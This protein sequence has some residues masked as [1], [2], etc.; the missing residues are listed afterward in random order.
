[1]KSALFVEARPSRTGA[2]VDI[3]IPVLNEERALPGAIRTVSAYLSE[4][5][6]LPWRI[7]IADNG[8]TDATWEIAQD[9]AATVPGVFAMR[10]ERRGKGAAVKEAWRRSPADVVAFLDVDLS[11]GLEALPP[12][13][14]AVAA[15]HCEV[16]IGTRLGNGSRT[17]RGTKRELISRTYNGLLR[18]GFGARFTDATC[19]FKAARADVVRPLLP[20]VKDEGWFFDTELLLLAQYNGAR[21]REVPV[22]WIE[23]E[24]SSVDIWRTS[25]SNLRGL[26]RVARAIGSR[27]ARVQLPPIPDLRPSHPDAAMATSGTLGRVA[28]FA[29]IGLVSAVMHVLLYC[30][31]RQVWA[32][33]VA[34]LAALALTSA[35]NTEA[36]RRWT[37]NRV[38]RALPRHVRTA[39]MFTLTYTISTCALLLSQ[40]SSLPWESAVVVGAAFA[41]VAL[42]FLLL[43]RW[44]FRDLL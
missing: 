44:I 19:G 41:M 30:V 22:D 40:A 33:P 43:D 6:Q 28:T 31:A 12:L 20:K 36:N 26:H 21:I 32:I 29:L 3:V 39:V 2:S 38:G 34:N 27:Q 24:D 11:T 4:A 10:I 9:L 8:S 13:V 15:G 25:L 16:A 18:L 5:L 1:M 14:T 42:R 35:A 37:F 17:M 23:D 7:T